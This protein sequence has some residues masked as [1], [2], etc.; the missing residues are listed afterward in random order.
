MFVTKH[1]GH[2]HACNP[3]LWVGTAVA[4]GYAVYMTLKC[5]SASA[6]A[7]SDAKK[8]CVN[9]CVKKD[10]DKVVDSFDIE[11]MGAKTVFCRCWR[12]KKF[13]LCDGAHIKHN[14]D[15]G[16]NVGPLIVQKKGN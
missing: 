9:Q 5:K 14:E 3:Y 1:L 4:V 2:V 6:A 8:S 10:A 11:D 12:S 13:P 7:N 16:D 15:T